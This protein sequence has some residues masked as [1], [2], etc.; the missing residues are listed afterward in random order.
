LPWRG[1]IGPYDGSTAGFGAVAA[2]GKG[3][4]RK[5]KGGNSETL[6]K[7]D[8]RSY[9]RGRGDDEKKVDSEAS[10]REEEEKKQ[11]E[12]VQSK[13]SNVEESRL[14]PPEKR[15]VSAYGVWVS[16][17]MLQQTRVEAVIPYYLKCE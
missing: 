13:D 4:A 3:D 8:I 6:A 14:L 17:I 9:F 15:E 7:K 11:E 16:E 1:D 12:D 10:L 5:K 2:A